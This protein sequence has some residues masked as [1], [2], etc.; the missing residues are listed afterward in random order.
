MLLVGTSIAI[1][2]VAMLVAGQLGAYLNLRER[3][4]GTTATWLPRGAHI[5]EVATNTMLITMAGMAVLAQWAVYAMHR[6]DR[7]NAS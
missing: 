1:S 3:A 7:R 5:N 6:G 2:G 4:G